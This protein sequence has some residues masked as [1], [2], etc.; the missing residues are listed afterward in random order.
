MRLTLIYLLSLI[1]SLPAS[2]QRRYYDILPEKD[3]CLEEITQPCVIEAQVQGYPW[4]IKLGDYTIE[5]QK[6]IKDKN[7]LYEKSYTQ[8][9]ITHQDSL[10]HTSLSDYNLERHPV[11]EID[12]MLSIDDFKVP[13]TLPVTPCISLGKDVKM[14]GLVIEDYPGTQQL[15]IIDIPQNATI[16]EYLDR[17]N[18]PDFTLPGGIY[19]LAMFPYEGYQVLAYLSGAKINAD[20]WPKGRIKAYLSPSPAGDY[21]VKWLDSAGTPVPDETTAT[22]ENNILTINFP[23]YQSRLRFLKIRQ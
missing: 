14:Q 12:S 20:H 17:E 2:A 1:I 22:I 3:T 19:T 7:S 11:I 6:V 18:H 13:F 4:N 21:V 15:K 8:V 5:Y 23:L 9:A 10:I 16:W